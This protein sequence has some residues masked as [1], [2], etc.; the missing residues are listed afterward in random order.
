MYDVLV[1]LNKN[2]RDAIYREMD[3]RFLKLLD[4]VRQGPCSSVG[5]APHS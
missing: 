3:E 4:D 2:V 1:L 5:R